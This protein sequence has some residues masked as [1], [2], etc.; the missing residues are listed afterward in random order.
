MHSRKN[1]YLNFLNLLLYPPA[2]YCL[3]MAAMSASMPVP[4]A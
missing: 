2:S 4:V 1:H 3:R